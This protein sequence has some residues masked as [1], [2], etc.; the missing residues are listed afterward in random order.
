MMKGSVSQ[1]GAG[2]LTLFRQVCSV[3][4]TLRRMPQIQNEGEHLKI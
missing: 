3:S 1:D 4:L 2:I